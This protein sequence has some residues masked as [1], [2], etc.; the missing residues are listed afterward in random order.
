MVD[1][2]RP[3]H[4]AILAGT[5]LAL[6]SG[7]LP[8][9]E[10]ESAVES[11]SV[12]PAT[13]DVLRTSVWI[14]LL[15]MI[16][17]LVMFVVKASPGLLGCAGAIWLNVSIIVWFTGGKAA[18]IVPKNVLPENAAARLGTG[19]FIGIAGAVLMTAGV[20]MVLAEQTWR[21]VPPQLPRWF[22][23]TSVAMVVV[24]VAV[25]QFRWFEVA[26]GNFRWSLD[27][28]II[29]LFGDTMSLVLVIAVALVILQFVRPRRWVAFVLLGDAAVLGLM[30]LVAVG[31]NAAIER[32][33]HELLRRVKFLGDA[34]AKL[35]STNGPLVFVAAAMILGGYA[36]LSLKI[37]A[38][39]QNPPNILS[40]VADKV[41]RIEQQ[42]SQTLPR[43]TGDDLPF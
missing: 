4:L 9:F 20:A 37:C 41:G 13:S 2:R 18:A 10:A 14:V 8:W 24:C 43:P 16:A 36:A 31:S 38:R 23:V 1:L 6:T 27:F 30:S 22:F 40:R 34:R 19:A 42:S 39:R 26:G 7:F 25:R 32:G 17:G 12:T 28:D 21:L 5:F 29:P 3:S 15:A 33:A 35:T 11:V